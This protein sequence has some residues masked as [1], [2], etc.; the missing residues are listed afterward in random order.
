M[1]PHRQP[2]LVLAHEMTL[3]DDPLPGPVLVRQAQQ[4]LPSL[5]EPGRFLP[6]YGYAHI[7]CRMRPALQHYTAM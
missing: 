4:Q 2:G 5:R 7:M 3:H 6:A 1:K